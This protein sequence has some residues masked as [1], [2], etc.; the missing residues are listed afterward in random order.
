MA[1]FLLENA[2]FFTSRLFNPQFDY[3][4]P[5]IDGWNFAYPSLTAMANYLCKNCSPTP[6]PVAT[7]R[8]LPTEDR[9]MTTTTTAQP[10]LK[11]SW[12]KHKPSGSRCIFMDA[13]AI[14]T[15]NL[16][17]AHVTRDSSGP[18]TWA[19]VYSMQ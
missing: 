3:V 12:P 16:S 14:K 4:P 7:V 2:Y 9:Q 19:I 8:P 17:K 11:Y 13:E 1:S 18:A 10:L 15:S 5:G 6:Y